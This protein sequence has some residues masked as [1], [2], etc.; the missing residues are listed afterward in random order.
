LVANYGRQSP[1]I[2]ELARHR[3]EKTDVGRLAA[4][5]AAWCIEHELALYPLDW[6]ERRSGRLYF[7]MPSIEP[8]LEEVLAVFAD[9]YGYTEEDRTRERKRVLEAIAWVSPFAP[10]PEPAE[11]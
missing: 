3:S 4:A 10:A 11:A 8:V 5:E 9:A 6:V 1:D 2:I 7:D